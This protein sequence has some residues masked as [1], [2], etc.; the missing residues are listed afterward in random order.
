LW[1]GFMFGRWMFCLTTIGEASIGIR[2]AQA[3]SSADQSPHIF[4]CAWLSLV[5]VR[6]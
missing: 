1:R 3:N 4:F 5:S 6:K 2:P